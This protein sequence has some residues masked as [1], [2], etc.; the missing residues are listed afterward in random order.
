[1]NKISSY[2]QSLRTPDPFFNISYVVMMLMMALLPI[3]TYFMWPF[4][5]ILMLLFICNWN[6]REKWENFKANDGIPYGFFLLGVFLIPV[7][8]FINSTN[9]AIAWRS[10]ECHIWFLFAPLVFLTTSAKL[11]S[12]RHLSTLLLLFSC[13]NQEIELLQS[14]NV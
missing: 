10:L 13:M 5:V 12:K 4:G 3:T 14:Q 6:W 7:L 1:M 8:G 9:T 11:W 2:L